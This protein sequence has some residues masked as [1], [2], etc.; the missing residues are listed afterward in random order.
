MAECASIRLQD[1]GGYAQ[2][3]SI[4]HGVHILDV[5]TASQDSDNL[6]VHDDVLASIVWAD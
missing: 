1:D 2:V 3:T 6:D 4:A 5:L